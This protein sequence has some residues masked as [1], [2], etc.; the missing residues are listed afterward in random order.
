VKRFDRAGERRR[1]YASAMAMLRKDESEGSSY[2]EIAEFLHHRGAKQFV[3]ADLE[4]LFRRVAFNVAIGNRDDHLR[5]HGFI[6]TTNGWR[7]AP[8][9]DVNPNIEKAEHVLNLDETDNRPNFAT[10]ID[11]SEWYSLSKDRGAKIV[12]E[13]TQETR[14]WRQWAARANIARADIE[15]TAVAFAQSDA[16]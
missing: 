10:V 15:L 3:A 6:L 12:G 14:K 11:T 2:L 7:L 16:S 1:F 13:I 5:N 4:Q 8:A 9:F